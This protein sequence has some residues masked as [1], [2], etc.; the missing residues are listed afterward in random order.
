MQALYAFSASGDS[1][2]MKAEKEMLESN[3]GVFVLY[4]KLLQ[5]YVELHHVAVKIIEDNKRKHIPSFE[6]LNP[7]V[8]FVENPA[9]LNIVQSEELQR[10]VNKHKISWQ[11]EGELIRK[12]YNAV[13]SSE[14]YCTYMAAPDMDFEG[15]RRFLTDLLVE[16]IEPN[17]LIKNILGEESIYWVDDYYFACHVLEKTLHKMS[18]EALIIPS[19]Y[20]DQEEDVHFVKQ[21]FRKAI[22]LKEEHEKMIATKTENWEAERIAS[23][24]ML[25]MNMALTEMREFSNIPV[26]VSLNEFIEISKYYSSSKSKV[27]ING[28]LDKIVKDYLADGKIKKV[29]R[30]LVE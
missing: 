26:K 19:V 22:V 11:N 16:V 27:F 9:L 17:D 2:V 14:I 5:L 25:L 3:E 13:R 1:N 29:G 10:L 6:D 24:D 15:H 21:L 7:N 8:R 30:G 18:Q 20:K 23:M 28:I 12:L 4:L